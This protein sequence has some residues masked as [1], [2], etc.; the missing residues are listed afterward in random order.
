MA[1]AGLSQVQ[2]RRLTCALFVLP[3]LAVVF[4]FFL[5][6]MLRALLLSFTNWDG[7]SRTW[8]WV[9]LRNFQTV[10][11]D[12]TFRQIS[13]NTVYLAIIYVPV[14]NVVADRDDVVAPRS[15]LPFIDAIPSRDK[16]NLIFPTGHVGAIVS[17]AA[18]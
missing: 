5:Y 3:A 11:L 1:T 14:L 13:F 10:V 7:I 2:R 16:A 9:G 8:Q 15:S 17:S 4:L 18:Q 6:P 12:S